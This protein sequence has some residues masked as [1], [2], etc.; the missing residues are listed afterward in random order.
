[1]DYKDY[2]QILGVPR[3][4]TQDEIKKAYRKLARQYHPDNN[5]GDKKAEA[6]FKELN[7]AN[8]VLSDPGKRK[9]YDTLGARWQ[10]YERMGGQP[11]GFDWSQWTTD[12]R[13]TGDYGDI[14]GDGGF[15]D[16]FTRI[17]GGVGE[18]Q[19]G[20][21]RSRSR[22][23][24]QRRPMR[25]RDFEQPVQIS[26]RD[27]YAGTTIAVQKDGQKIEV[28]I[29]AGVKTGSKVRV[30]GQ[31]GAGLQGGATGDL[32]L[33]VD[34]AT[35]QVFER[36]GDDLKTNVTVDLYTLILGGEVTVPTMTGDVKLKIP[37]ETQPSRV[38]RL[39][40]Q[41]MPLLRDPQTHGDLLVKIQASLPTNLTG[42]EKTLFEQLARY[43]K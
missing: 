18:G 25:G 23:T 11:G 2:Y 27:A 22:T 32:F 3:K 8:E 29:P 40:G 10:E 24:G 19:P 13:G 31:G 21:A 12:T 4:A 28:K 30:A 42:V 35:D 15:S 26:L 1:M 34:V 7:E 5:P 33:V 16:F 36:D 43:R 9:K 39:R 17:F 38:F 14:F 20:G 37:A 41:G 6:K